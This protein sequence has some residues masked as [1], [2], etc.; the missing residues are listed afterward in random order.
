MQSSPQPP[1]QPPTSHPLSTFQIRKAKGFDRLQKRYAFEVE[2]SAY[3]RLSVNDSFRLKGAYIRVPSRELKT[4]G[5]RE[6]KLHPKI[7]FG[8][9]GCDP[10]CLQLIRD[11]RRSRFLDK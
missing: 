10:I 3:E 11:S 1:P 8:S 7:T 9:T 4:K 2:V 6:F 5:T